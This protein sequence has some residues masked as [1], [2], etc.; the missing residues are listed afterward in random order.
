MKH[1]PPD[2]ESKYGYSEIIKDKLYLGGEDDIDELLYGVVEARN[3]NRTGKFE[4]QPTPKIDVWIDLRDIRSSNR[5]V[6]TP[7][8]IEYIVFP[9]RDGELSEAKEFLPKAKEALQ[10]RIERN[11]RILVTCHQG[12]SRSVMLL[13]WFLGEKGGSFTK[14]FKEIKAKR[15][16]IEPDKNFKPLIEEWKKEYPN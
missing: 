10:N 3:I 13:L 11:K 8:G 4:N 9:F 12:R 5:N 15:P 16:I 7:E 1:Q 14:A 6:Y 2:W